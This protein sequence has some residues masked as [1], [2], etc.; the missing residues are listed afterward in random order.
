MFVYNEN[1]HRKVKPITYKVNENGCWICTSHAVQRTGYIHIK[2]YGKTVPL[3][4]YVYE[5]EKGP[6]PD[7]KVV[8]HTCD[9]RDCFNPNH[10]RVG[11]Y[12]ENSEDMVKKSRQA[13]GSRNGGGGKLTEEQVREI[14][15]SKLNQYQLARK[16]G[17]TQRVISLIMRGKLWS[18][19]E[20]ETYYVERENFLGENSPKA[21]LTD[22][23]VRQIKLKLREGRSAASLAREYGVE[24]TAILRIKHNKTW[25]HIKISD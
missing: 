12:K 5:R 1:Y 24:D 3:H 8:M 22:E 25:K 14:K 13:K 16:Y 21:K 20:G 4:R 10:L 19:I 15:T 11:T 17:V 9:Q 18:H 23:K 7:G 6:I 2:R